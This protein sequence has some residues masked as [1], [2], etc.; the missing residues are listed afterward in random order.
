MQ[1]VIIFCF[2]GRE[3]YLSIQ[4]Q[5]ILQIL[6]KWYNIEY[7]LWDFSRNIEDHKYLIEISSKH[8]QIVYFDKFYQGDNTNITCV[9]QVGRHCTCVKCRV[10]Q[11]TEPYKHYASSVYKDAIFIKIDD[12]VVSFPYRELK[13][14]ILI[15]QKNPKFIVSANVINNGICAFYNNEL[16]PIVI[17]KKISEKMYTLTDWFYFCTN[18]DF[19]R[20]CHEFFLS[21]EQQKEETDLIKP[22][23][24][25][26]VPPHT[27]FSINTIGFMHNIM[28]EIAAK[29]DESDIS[30]N[31]E[32]TISYSFP[33]LIYNGFT[34]VHFHFSDQR[35]QIDDSVE[36]EL[37]K[38]YNNVAKKYISIVDDI[39]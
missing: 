3:K 19:F 35:T 8:K 11:W 24:L 14:Y 32:A 33:F 9:K 30:C 10:G 26:Q 37:L 21:R 6:K 15:I 1:K 34:C 13:K 38:Q 2:A 17:K 31:D 7:H 5:Y 22:D 16:K 29:L 20:I 39:Y 18:V 23:L 25:S 27:K 28:K 4:L 36:N 12:D